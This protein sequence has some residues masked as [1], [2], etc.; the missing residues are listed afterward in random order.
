MEFMRKSE[1]SVEFPECGILWSFN[2]KLYKM[3]SASEKDSLD[4]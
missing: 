2:I 1:Q 3:S 4:L